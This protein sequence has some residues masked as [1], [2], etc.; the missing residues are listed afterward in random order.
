[1]AWLQCSIPGTAGNN[2]SILS[3]SVYDKNKIR[4][5]SLIT[6][7]QMPTRVPTYFSLIT[8][9]CLWWRPN[10]SLADH[11]N[12]IPYCTRSLRQGY[13]SAVLHSLHSLHKL[14]TAT[15][16]WRRAC[17]MS[18]DE[19]MRCSSLPE[20]EAYAMFQ[21]FHA[22]SRSLPLDGSRIKV[23]IYCSCIRLGSIPPSQD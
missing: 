22:S 9:L 19:L 5:S 10:A 3:H 23:R 21:N 4:R 7:P 12:R 2:A 13:E 11:R 16:Y 18:H 15:I 6:V 20:T 14:T 8:A 17:P 1:M